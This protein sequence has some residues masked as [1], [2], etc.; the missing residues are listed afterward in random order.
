MV[1]TNTNNIT[2]GTTGALPKEGIYGGAIAHADG[3]AALNLAYAATGGTATASTNISNT[4]VI[5][6]NWNGITTRAF[7]YANGFGNS[8][9]A[10]GTGT[11]GHAEAHVVINNTGGSITSATG[12]GIYGSAKAI[13]SGYGFNAFGGLTTAIATDNENNN[14]PIVS[15]NDGIVGLSNAQDNGIGSTT[16][17]GSGTGGIAS[18]S[19][20]VTNGAGGVITVSG[21]GQEGIDAQSYAG[22]RGVGYTAQGGY[23]TA[24]TSITNAGAIKSRGDGLYSSST[25]RAGWSRS[26]SAAVAKPSSPPPSNGP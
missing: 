9:L 25:A 11:G 24:S 4:G 10:G 14:A 5:K 3:D 23:A 21:V 7:A 26:W 8:T 13:A 15:V 1:I 6:S 20:V 12:M 16:F 18:A 17:P 2:T 19:T 22:A